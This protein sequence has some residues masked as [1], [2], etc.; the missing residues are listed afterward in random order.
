MK[1]I[2][3]NIPPDTNYIVSK[4]VHKNFKMPRD[5]AIKLD[6]LASIRKYRG[7]AP[8]VIDICIEYFALDSIRQ[9]LK[10]INNDVVLDEE[11]A[12]IEKLITE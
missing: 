4:F 10:T 1:K 11:K 3:V 2:E 9:E 8:L 7:A 6:A 5:L 12:K